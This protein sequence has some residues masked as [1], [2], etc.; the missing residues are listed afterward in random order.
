MIHKFVFF[1][2]LSTL[3]SEYKYKINTYWANFKTISFEALSLFPRPPI[4][5]TEGLVI[6]F[7]ALSISISSAMI[8]LFW[9]LRPMLQCVQINEEHKDSS[10]QSIVLLLLM[11]FNK[12]TVKFKMLFVIAISKARLLIYKQLN[13]RY[14]NAYYKYEPPDVPDLEN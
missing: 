11:T 14:C 4:T 9:T 13:K 1:S 2:H 3:L 7:L 12:V 8:C 5:A 6:L 10:Y